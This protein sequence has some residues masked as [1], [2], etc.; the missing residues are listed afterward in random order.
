MRRPPVL[1]THCCK[2]VSDQLW[3]AWLNQPPVASI[4]CP[5]T[6]HSSV[7]QSRW[8]IATEGYPSSLNQL[9]TDHSESPPLPSAS[10]DLRSSRS[11]CSVWRPP[12][13]NRADQPSSRGKLT[14]IM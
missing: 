4:H 10:R 11:R 6:E 3:M 7:A 9:S 8:V 5:G 13:S 12:V 1:N 14:S 2:L